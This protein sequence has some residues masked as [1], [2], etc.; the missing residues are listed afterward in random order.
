MERTKP[1]V[2]ES[3]STDNYQAPVSPGLPVTSGYIDLM[4]VNVQ[5]GH[6]RI[7]FNGRT[8]DYKKQK[9]RRKSNKMEKLSKY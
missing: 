4:L 9:S 2:T 1:D 8:K 5:I 7:D 6:F 3:L